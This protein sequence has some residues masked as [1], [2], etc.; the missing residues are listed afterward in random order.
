[1]GSGGDGPSTQAGPGDLAGC[2]F[3]LELDLG[4]IKRPSQAIS[5]MVPFVRQ[6]KILKAHQSG[7]PG[8]GEA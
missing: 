1:M 6:P 2:V 4:M 7:V 5:R 8:G 3:G